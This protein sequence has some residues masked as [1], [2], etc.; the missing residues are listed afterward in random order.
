M[1]EDNNEIFFREIMK[2]SRLDMPFPDVEDDIMNHIEAQEEM[3]NEQSQYMRWSWISFVTG[4]VFGVILTMLL[5]NLEFQIQGISAN[6]LILLIELVI[7]IAIVL[8]LENLILYS[9]HKSHNIN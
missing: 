9:R 5:P 3:R 2:K 6:S 7:A 1:E 8:N 4:T